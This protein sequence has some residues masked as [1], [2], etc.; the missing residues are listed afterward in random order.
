V[1]W[2]TGWRWPGKSQA[3]KGCIGIELHQGQA[4]GV[5]FNGSGVTHCYRPADGDSGLEGLSQWLLQLPLAKAAVHMVLDHQHYE[6]HMVEAAPVPDEELSDAM[7]F[8][9]KDML[10]M[11]L[12]DAIVQATRLPADAYRG[13]QDMAFV[14][15]VRRDHIRKLVKWCHNRDL[16]LQQISLPEFSLLNLVTAQMVEHSVALLR[17]DEHSGALYVYYDGALYLVRSLAIG[18]AD[19]QSNS[20]S[21]ELTLDSNEQLERL[22]L[23]LQR[24][25]DFYESQIGMGSIGQIWV[26]KPDQGDLDESLPRLEDVLN[27]PVRQISLDSHYNQMPGDAG[28]SASLLTALG[29]CLSHGA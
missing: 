24:S 12:D 28:L 15:A 17:L 26:L 19:L 11:P 23:E 20:A 3:A 10:S 16:E 25:M 6:L 1:S 7:R 8:R 27:I 29:G 14:S 21:E 13:R 4:F 5:H 22:A 18:Y 2:K 9:V